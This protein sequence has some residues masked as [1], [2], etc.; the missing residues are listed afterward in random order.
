MAGVVIVEL[1]RVHAPPTVAVALLALFTP[2]SW[3]FPV[4]VLLATTALYGVFLAWR[5]V[6]DRLSGT[7][8]EG[9]PGGARWGG[10][11]P[12]TR[13]VPTGRGGPSPRPPPNAGS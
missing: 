7:P 5:R 2:P 13:L 9:G 11:I 3:I 12:D 1:L 10:H 4:S 8:G 6:F